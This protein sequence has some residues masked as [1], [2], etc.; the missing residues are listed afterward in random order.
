[1]QAAVVNVLDQAPSDAEAA[2]IVNAGVSAWLSLKER[3][4]VMPDET[5]L[6]LGATGVAGQLA[7]QLTLRRIDLRLM[8]GRFG[9]VPLEYVFGAIPDVLQLAAKGELRITVEPVPL[10]DVENAW[11]RVEKGRRIVFTP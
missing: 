11:N 7:L 8:G 2:A 1:M 6:V 10:A 3:A 9:S 4:V 5:V